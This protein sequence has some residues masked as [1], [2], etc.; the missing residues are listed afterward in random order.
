MMPSSPKSILIK[1]LKFSVL[2]AESELYNNH[3]SDTSPAHDWVINI[4]LSQSLLQQHKNTKIHTWAQKTVMHYA[5]KQKIYGVKFL[6]VR[7]QWTLLIS[8]S[9]LILCFRG[10]PRGIVPVYRVGV[11]WAIIIYYY[12]Y[13]I[14]II[15]SRT[16]WTLVNS[17]NNI[18][19]P[20]VHKLFTQLMFPGT[21]SFSNG[22]ISP[23]NKCLFRSINH[24]NILPYQL[25]W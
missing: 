14:I 13:Y 12:I 9:S 18:H 20:V 3:S 22:T 6:F 7:L 10:Q 11:G 19:P 24:K 16:Y 5:H 23:G 1:C 15:K 4:I 25:R 17:I 21:F 2:G 8:P